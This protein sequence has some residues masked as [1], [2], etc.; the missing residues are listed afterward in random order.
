MACVRKKQRWGCCITPTRAASTPTMRFRTSLKNTAAFDPRLQVAIS[1]SGK[2]DQT[3]ASR[4]TGRMKPTLWQTKNRGNLNPIPKT[5]QQCGAVVRLPSSGRI[6]SV[7]EPI[8]RIY[9]KFWTRLWLARKVLVNEDDVRAYRSRPASCHAF[10]TG[11]SRYSITV[12]VP[13]RISALVCMPALRANR[14]LS[15]CFP[16]SRCMAL[17]V[18]SAL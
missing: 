9:S 3:A 8:E 14:W 4:K 12:R 2:L 10:L 1:A 17:R 16:I 13:S 6:N 18:T 11:E 7:I 5:L 15:R